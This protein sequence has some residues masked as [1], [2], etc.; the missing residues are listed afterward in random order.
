MQNLH[1]SNYCVYRRVIFSDIHETLRQTFWVVKRRFAFPAGTISWNQ[2]NSIP[3]QF[4]NEGFQA[5]NRQKDMSY[6]YASLRVL[7]KWNDVIIHKRYF[8]RWFSFSEKSIW[9]YKTQLVNLCFPHFSV[10]RK[11][12]LSRPTKC[13]ELLL[14]FQEEF[15]SGA[16]QSESNGDLAM[17]LL[18]SSIKS[19]TRQV[20][21]STR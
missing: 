19:K 8:D 11:Q 16:E 15:K 5:R 13:S 9:R 12:K 2:T 18:V 17:A 14:I 1:L 3:N 6:I 21:P 7:H 4:T 10:N 20:P